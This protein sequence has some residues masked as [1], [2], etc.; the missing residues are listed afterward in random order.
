MST[1]FWYEFI[2]IMAIIKSKKKLIQQEVKPIKKVLVAN[3]GEIACRIIRTLTEMG[4]ES[5]AIYATPDAQSLHVQMANFAIPLPEATTPLQSYLSIENIIAIAKENNV[6][7]IHPGFGLLSENANFAQACQDADIIFIGPSPDVILQMGDKITAKQ[8][9]KKSN[10]PIVPGFMPESDLAFDNPLWV[11]EAEKIT[12][13]VLVKAAAGGGGKGMRVVQSSKELPEAVAAAQREAKSAFLDSRVF[14]EK[15]IENPRHI[16][17]QILADNAGPSGHVLHLFERDCSTQRRHQKV[18]EE[19][20]A[21]TLPGDIR[22]AILFSAISLAKTV[23]YTN[24]GT[25]E[26]IYDVDAEKYYFLEMNTRLQVE[27]PITESITGLDIVQKQ[28]EI[29]EGK[30]LTL[31]QKDITA[32]GHSIECRIYAE[33]P[34]RQFMP[35]I[36]TLHCFQHPQWPGVRVDTGVTQGDTVSIDFDPMLAKV[37]CVAEN[38]AQ[39]RLKM[40]AFLKQF[41]VLGVTTNIQYL[42]QLLDCPDFISETVSTKLIE[43]NPPL[44]SESYSENSAENAE[45]LEQL[46]SIAASSPSSA[47]KSSDN[48]GEACEYSPWQLVQS[49]G[50]RR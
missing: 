39:A 14:L 6:D 26:F 25:V 37:S 7:A 3:R 48:T 41:I 45:L 21:P 44:I 46:F 1:W 40:L 2:E 22:H 43:K 35:S 12:Y 36:G 4:I 49:T 31:T 42:C 8:L 23:N 11:S 5:V 30:A 19:A 18:I 32:R 34:Q 38:R 20:P 16:E 50:R 27:H 9:A 33:D 15:Y 47:S 24:A 13:P 10:V 29:A 28:I 17:V